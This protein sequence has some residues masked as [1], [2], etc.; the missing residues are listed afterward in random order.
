MA[1]EQ[2]RKRGGKSSFMKRNDERQRSVELPSTPEPPPGMPTGL[3]ALMS[4]QGKGYLE[5]IEAA[6]KTAASRSRN[7]ELREEMRKY[8]E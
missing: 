3:A 1:L 2:K 5:R 6:Q 7:R 8:G 4:G